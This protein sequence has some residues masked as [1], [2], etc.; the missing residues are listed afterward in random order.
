MPKLSL[1]ERLVLSCRR[2]ILKAIGEAVL[3]LAH[4]R[5][6]RKSLGDGG[7]KRVAEHFSMET[8]LN[9]H[10]ELYRTLLAR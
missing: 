2:T 6:L 8:C 4:D 9:A 10:L 3:R 1:T 7:R 5:N